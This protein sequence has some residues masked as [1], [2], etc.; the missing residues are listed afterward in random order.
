MVDLV[1]VILKDEIV[2]VGIQSVQFQ[3]NDNQMI[4]CL[5]V[6]V[7]EWDGWENFDTVDMGEYKVNHI[8]KLN[9]VMFPVQQMTLNSLNRYGWDFEKCEN[10][11]CTI[12]TKP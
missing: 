5:G 9:E 4:W 3:M 7:D 11:E 2:L 1:D 10:P 12:I 6:D 8:G